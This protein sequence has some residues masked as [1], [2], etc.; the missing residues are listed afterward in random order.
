MPLVKDGDGLSVAAVFKR[1]G[2]E[3]QGGWGRQ[4]GR[5]CPVCSFGCCPRL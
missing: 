3:E 5:S 2:K 4:K 1:P